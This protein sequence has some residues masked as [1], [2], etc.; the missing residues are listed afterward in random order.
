MPEG[1]YYYLTGTPNPGTVFNDIDR[2]FRYPNNL[3]NGIW[4]QN[5]DLIMVGEFNQ[6]G[7]WSHGA[8]VTGYPA[9]PTN[10]TGGYRRMVQMPQTNLVAYTVSGSSD[11]MGPAPAA[12]V[13]LA[14][15]DRFTGAIGTGV[16]AQFSDGYSGTCNV[17][18][19]SVTDFFCLQN[20]TTI[21]RYS[22]AEGS[23]V[24]S[25]IGTITLSAALP[26]AATC[27]GGHCY[28]GSFAW[29]GAY[30]Y[31]AE[32]QSSPIN[33]NYYVYA[34]NGVYVGS[35]VVG[36]TGNINGV[37]FDWSVGRYAIHDGYGD[38]TGG[39]VYE[40]VGSNSDSQCYGPVSSNHTFHP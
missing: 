35:Y 30:F 27:E 6:N 4:H 5:S 39:T 8:D 16:V 14:T 24:L 2:C 29:D 31:F 1:T 33:L 37:Y 13:R 36:G 17:L 9:N 38:R 19:S 25:F 15:I 11:G 23:P 28:A 40:S 20:T 26:T 32:S 22:T 3:T 10:G 21:R 18:S 12:D 34:E 7:Y